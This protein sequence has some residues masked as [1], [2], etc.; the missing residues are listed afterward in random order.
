MLSKE[1]KQLNDKFAQIDKIVEEKVASIMENYNKN[2]G[3]MIIEKGSEIIE[4]EFPHDMG[5]LPRLTII[6]GDNELKE[7]CYYMMCEYKPDSLCFY[8]DSKRE[9]QNE[10]M[11]LFWNNYLKEKKINLSHNEPYLQTNNKN[12][13]YI[14][15]IKVS[16]DAKIQNILLEFFLLYIQSKYKINSIK[17]IH[18]IYKYGNLGYYEI[19]RPGKLL[20]A[21]NKKEDSKKSIK[22]VDELSLINDKR[23]KMLE[24]IYEKDSSQKIIF[25]GYLVEI[26]ED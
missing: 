18:A 19:L 13:Y 4:I 21:I 10:T 2:S 14:D 12:Y 24:I 23:Y 25:L 9:K 20:I 15:K 26:L 17:R 3:D 11:T 7:F 6:N 16:N 5:S 22:I 8:T 1:E